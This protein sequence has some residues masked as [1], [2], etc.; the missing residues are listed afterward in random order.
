MVKK[1]Q[2]Q[3]SYVPPI[4][5]T[6]LLTMW[7]RSWESLVESL[8]HG[9]PRSSE[10]FHEVRGMLTALAITICIV[11]ISLIKKYTLVDSRADQDPGL[12]RN[13]IDRQ[14]QPR[15]RI[16]TIIEYL[17]KTLFKSAHSSYLN[18]SSATTTWR[19]ETRQSLFV[20]RS[21]EFES[22]LSTSWLEYE[23]EM[24]RRIC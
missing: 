2:L 9:L 11:N 22:I 15:P 3:D 10:T 8:T 4:P 20:H 13:T 7:K 6:N 12:W 17:P 23:R 19:L 1:R 24:A 16:T 5:N 14:R 18:F 21:R